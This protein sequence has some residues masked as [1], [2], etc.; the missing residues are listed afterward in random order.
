MIALIVISQVHPASTPAFLN[1]CMN[2]FSPSS[3]VWNPLCGMRGSSGRLGRAGRMEVEAKGRPPVW[4]P[5]ERSWVVEV[6][7]VS[8]LPRERSAFSPGVNVGG[9]EGLCK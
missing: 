1:R 3:T 4:A 9:A 6:V 7:G 5:T 2:A 8:A